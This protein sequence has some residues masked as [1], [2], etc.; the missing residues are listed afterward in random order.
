VIERLVGLQAQLARPPFLQLWSRIA[1]FQRSELRS[2]IESRPFVLGGNGLAFRMGR[3]APVRVGA[4]QPTAA[5]PGPR[6]WA[7]HP[8]L[9]QP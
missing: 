8:A 4:A 2:L 6:L 1:G 7:P 3:T 9:R 5:P